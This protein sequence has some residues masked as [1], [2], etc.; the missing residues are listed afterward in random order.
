MR[1]CHMD[2]M[3]STDANGEEMSAH[4]GRCKVVNIT[5]ALLFCIKLSPEWPRVLTVSMWLDLRVY[6]KRLLSA[7]RR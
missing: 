5:I 2:F 6:P 4:L 3:A 1:N 7:Q